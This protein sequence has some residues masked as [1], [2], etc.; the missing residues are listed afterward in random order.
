LPK[1]ISKKVSAERIR[2]SFS[3]E[4]LFTI[5]SFPGL[6]PEMGGNTNYPLMKQLSFGT[7]ITF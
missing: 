3:A 1:Q 2:F 4:N 5:S 6:D 7:I